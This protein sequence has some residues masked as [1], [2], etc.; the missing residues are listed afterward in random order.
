MSKKR[1]TISDIKAAALLAK[2]GVSGIVDIVEAIHYNALRLSGILGKNKNRRTTGITGLVYRNIRSISEISG[3]G[4]EVLLNHLTKVINER[5][6]G[7]KKEALL[8]AING[9][10]GDYLFEKNSPLAIPMQLRYNGKLITGI[11]QTPEVGKKKIVLLVHGSCMNNLQW[12]RQGHDHGHML[13]QDLGYTPVYLVYNSGRHIS[14]NGKKLADILETFMQNASNNDEFVMLAHSM[15]GLVCRSAIHYA[16]KLGH[17]W[18]NQL[19]K[20]IFLGTPHHGAP[21]EKGGNLI[22]NMLGSNP[23]SAPLSR[24]GK[25]RSAGITDLRYG[26]IVDEDWNKYDRFAPTGDQRTPVPLPRDIQCFAIA[27]TLGKAPS[28]LKKEILGD[29]LVPWS[30]ALGKHKNPSFVLS[31]PSENQW[32][33]YN[34]NHLDLLSH[35]QVYARIKYWVTLN[36]GD[37]LV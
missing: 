13:S 9:V 10:L 15:G 26:N 33:G 18:A 28:K 29:G 37:E 34:M 4:F 19:K 11:E 12:N 6:P 24:L 21:L 14:D 8:A 35:S 32:T 5:T 36:D 16:M 2:D 17:N 20:L 25:I 30:S 1:S 22:D 7:Q 3:N 23:F 31:F 27:A